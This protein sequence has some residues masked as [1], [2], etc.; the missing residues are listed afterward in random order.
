MKRL[1]TFVRCIAFMLV[2]GIATHAQ[3]P[4]RA[5]VPFAFV[6]GDTLFPAGNYQIYEH[7]SMLRVVHADG[8]AKTVVASFGSQR[9]KN[10]QGTLL[11]VAR[12]GKHYL[13]KIYAPGMQTGRELPI[14]RL[15]R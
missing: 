10:E 13:A 3:S 7:G 1:P 12:D 11:F 5:H 9:G 6:V 2:F 8:T 14:K 15:A 4:M